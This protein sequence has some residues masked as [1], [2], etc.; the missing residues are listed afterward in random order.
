MCPSYTPYAKNA[1]TLQHT[2]DSTVPPNV[3]LSQYPSKSFI[4][5]AS[6]SPHEF[7]DYRPYASSFPTPMHS[8]IS[9]QYESALRSYALFNSSFDISARNDVSST[10][11]PPHLYYSNPPSES[12]F[13]AH[14]PAGPTIPALEFDYTRKE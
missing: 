6:S 13:M 11:Q 5:S 9:N 2:I 3:T 12:P 7:S 4:P 1:A 14:Q 10:Y 8:T